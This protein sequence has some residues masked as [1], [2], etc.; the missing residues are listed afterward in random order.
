MTKRVVPGLHSCI[1]VCH[2]AHT[3]NRAHLLICCIHTIRVCNQNA[4]RGI[5]ISGRH[6]HNAS[7]DAT[8][9]IVRHRQQLN[10]AR[11][12]NTVRENAHIVH[13]VSRGSSKSHGVRSAATSACSRSCCFG[14]SHQSRLGQIGRIGKPRGLAIDHPDARTRVSATRDLLNAAIIKTRSHRAFVFDEYL[15]KPRPSGA[16]FR[17]HPRQHGGIEFLRQINETHK[18]HPTRATPPTVERAGVMW[19]PTCP[20]HPPLLHQTKCAHTAPGGGKK[21][22]SW[23]RSTSCTPSPVIASARSM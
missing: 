14:R 1:A 23:G 20:I 11:L 8:S 18:G 4:S 15:G 5:G 10:L 16:S 3:E 2:C 9:S 22:P 19:V 6:L 12:R 21:S 7:V 17:Q 13:L